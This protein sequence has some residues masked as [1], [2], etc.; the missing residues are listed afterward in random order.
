MDTL[1]LSRDH[2]VE[3]E[4]SLPCKGRVLVRVGQQVKA[5]DPIAEAS[6]PDHYQFF[7][8]VREFG[9]NQEAAAAALQRKEGD[10]LN[11]GDLIAMKK[12][13]LSRYLWA[14]D[15]GALLLTRD[16]RL[17]M[18]YGENKLVLRAPYDA[19]VSQIL[20][21]KGAML[22]N[23]SMAVQGQLL[24]GQRASGAFVRLEAEEFARQ[25]RRMDRDLRGTVLWFEGVLTAKLWDRLKSIGLAALVLASAMPNLPFFTE[26]PPFTILLMMGAGDASLDPLSRELLMEM[27]G[28]IVILEPKARFDQTERPVLF[29]VWDPESH[30]LTKKAL[31]ELQIGSRVRLLG[32]PYQGLLAN[33]EEI[34]AK[35]ET[36]ASGAF[37]QAALLRID[38]DLLVRLPVSNF[39]LIVS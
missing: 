16:G 4:M 6:F 26:K 3:I 14:A 8:L 15:H 17:M 29:R 5:G 18:A 23:Q 2:A 7:D 35:P 21:G 20:T 39:E 24:Y 34:T 12:G 33:V 13:L 37:S 1:L 11:K 25:P 27:L 38:G 28:M 31:P 30:P 9:L 10:D 19:T 36:F 22:A 32:K